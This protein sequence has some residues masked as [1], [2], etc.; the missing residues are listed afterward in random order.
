MIFSTLLS[1]WPRAS[2]AIAFHIDRLPV[3]IG[4][5]DD[6]SDELHVVGEVHL[7]AISG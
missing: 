4:F 7:L 3:L 6:H 5:N 2:G 1:P